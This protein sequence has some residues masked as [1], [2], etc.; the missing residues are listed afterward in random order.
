[1]TRAEV[2]QV[3]AAAVEDLGVPGRD[4][5]FGWGLLR[6][7]RIELAAGAV[8]GSGNPNGEGAGA[9]PHAVVPQPPAD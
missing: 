4:P 2:K 3:L 7:N 8:P 5:V 6:M 9:Y 1:M